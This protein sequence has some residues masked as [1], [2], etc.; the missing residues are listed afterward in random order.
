MGFQGCAKNESSVEKCGECLVP[1]MRRGTV[2]LLFLV[3]LGYC[4]LGG[5]V[6]M[7]LERDQDIKHIQNTINVSQYARGKNFQSLSTRYKW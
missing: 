4:F 5:L 1:A 2:L 6:F 7:T 3:V